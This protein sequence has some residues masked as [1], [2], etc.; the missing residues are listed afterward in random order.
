[1]D[2]E[3]PAAEEPHPR[4]GRHDHPLVVLANRL[5]VQ[6]V[7]G[8][9]VTSPGGLVRAMLGVARSRRGAWVGWTGDID[10]PA[11]DGAARDEH[12]PDVEGVALVP[13]GLT[14]D[15]FAHYYEGVSN[16][17]LWPLYHDAIRPSSF[18]NESWAVYRDV[19]RRFAEAAADVVEPGG[20]VW[21]QDYHLHLVP[22][23]LRAIRPDVK[24][25]FF[26]H[27]PFPPQE[28]F[29]RLPWRE[30]ILRGLLGADVV[31]FQRRVAAE[32]FC[33]LA[34]R[35]LDAEVREGQRVVAEDGREA[36]IGTFPISIDVAEIDEI[37]ARPA[38]IEKV[39]SIRRRLGDP[40]A[41]LLGVD[42]LDYTKGIDVRLSAFGSLLHERSGG[43]RTSGAPRVV[44]VQIAVPNREGI[45]DYVEERKRV[46]QSVGE[47]NGDHASLGYPAVH[48]LRCSLGLDEL[49]PLYMAADLMVVTP[50]RDGM[51]LVAK[52]F[53]ASRRDGRGVLVLSEFAGAADELIDAVLVNPHDAESVV[54]ALRAALA[55]PDDEV[56]ER[57]RRLRSVVATHDVHEWAE[58]FLRCLDRRECPDTGG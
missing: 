47:V 32:N 29:M 19:N 44:L 20:T 45:G 46:E 7:D 4:T 1:M 35:L 9:W 50:L 22:G 12:L 18:D 14:A 54:A 8:S 34:H 48:Y 37:A 26:L 55:M 56:A 53:V 23:F 57:M 27:I 17:A 13:V 42:R 10:D 24:I 2:S 25:G 33:A 38:S 40:D 41:V 51:N 6:R 28:L 36:V 16:G 15:E 52:E 31:G 49:V 39:R 58:S 30:E 43:S 5:P 11:A 3:R 21:V